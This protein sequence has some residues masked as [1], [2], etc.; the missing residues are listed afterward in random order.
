MRRK[1]TIAVLASGLL[2]LLPALGGCADDSPRLDEHGRSVEGTPEADIESGG[3]TFNIINLL[4]AADNT[5]LVTG[6]VSR[7]FFSDARGNSMTVNGG[8]ELETY[9]FASKAALDTA[10][11]R[12]G[13]D[14][15]TIAGEQVTWPAPAHF[16]RTD[17]VLIIYFGED[18]DNRK[19]FETVFGAQVA[20]AR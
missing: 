7:P 15:S 4:R 2:F 1:I 3:P 18:P 20:G 17:R 13:A 5:V 14:G 9:E 16:Y 10:V 12:I 19:Q 6:S 11:A 8:I